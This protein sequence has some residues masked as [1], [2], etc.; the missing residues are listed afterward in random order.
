MGQ[1]RQVVRPDGQFKHL[2][3]RTYAAYFRSQY[4][5]EEG[6]ARVADGLTRLGEVSRTHRIPI[7]VMLFPILADLEAY[8][9]ADLHDQVAAAARAR[10]LEVVD[11]LE[12]YRRMSRATGQVPTLDGLHPDRAGHALAAV[13]ILRALLE[14]GQVGQAGRGLAPV[15][16]GDQP[17]ARIAGL[18]LHGSWEGREPAPHAPAAGEGG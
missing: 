18:L 11:L 10:S 5:T 17:E 16:A 1:V 7:Y 14:G 8:P 13:G 9:L 4:A 3:D 2:G 15:A 12:D 6:W